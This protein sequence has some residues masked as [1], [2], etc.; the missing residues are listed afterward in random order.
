MDAVTRTDGDGTGRLT[1]FARALLLVAVLAGCVTAVG[2]ATAENVTSAASAGDLQPA[3]A[4]G[5]QL[6]GATAPAAGAGIVVGVLVAVTV[7]T[8]R[9]LE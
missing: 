8:Y 5:A 6:P 7:F 9:E 1:T 4:A 3:E 2:T